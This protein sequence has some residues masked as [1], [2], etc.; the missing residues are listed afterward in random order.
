MLFGIPFAINGIKKSVHLG[1]VF[2]TQS[3]WPRPDFEVLLFSSF[4]Y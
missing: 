4:C 1:K 2:V 3:L